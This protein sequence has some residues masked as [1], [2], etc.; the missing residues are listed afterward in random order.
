MSLLEEEA[1]RIWV[2][3]QA[4]WFFAVLT[5]SG[6][7][8]NDKHSYYSHKAETSA[9]GRVR[10]TSECMQGKMPGCAAGDTVNYFT[11]VFLPTFT[12]WAAVM[13]LGLGCLIFL[14]RYMSPSIIHV[15]RMKQ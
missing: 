7:V 4:V 5:V 6:F 10:I 8:A 13:I 3:F 14:H 12:W 1:M 11:E 15:E 2:G 9:P